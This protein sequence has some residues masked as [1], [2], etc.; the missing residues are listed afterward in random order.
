V[1]SP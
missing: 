1:S